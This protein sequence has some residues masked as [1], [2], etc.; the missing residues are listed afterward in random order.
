MLLLPPYEVWVDDLGRNP[1]AHLR[2][3][4]QSAEAPTAAAPVTLAAR[5]FHVAGRDWRAKLLA[6]RDGDAWRGLIDFESAPGALPGTRS[7]T[8][9]V[10]REVSPADLRRSFLE[11]TSE[12]L[13]AFLRSTLP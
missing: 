2:E 7:R 8:A 6:H 5:A 12:T 9:L 1:A 13:A 11:F 4:E 3:L 10:F